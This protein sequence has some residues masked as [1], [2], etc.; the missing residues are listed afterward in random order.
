[1]CYTKR[2][3][4]RQRNRTLQLIET[5]VTANK[6]FHSGKQIQL[7]W[8]S[9][10]L[11]HGLQVVVRQQVM[12]LLRLQRYSALSMRTRLLLAS[13]DEGSTESGD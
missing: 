3:W 12:P 1:M 10:T 9:T 2:L 11:H 8:L 5:S 7:C 6:A 13:A 4:S